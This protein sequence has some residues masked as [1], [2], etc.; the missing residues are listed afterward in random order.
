MGVEASFPGKRRVLMKKQFNEN[1]SQ[2][3]IL[4]V[5]RAFVFKYF[6]GFG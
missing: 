1:S 4:E 3:E 2:E 6:F 5:E